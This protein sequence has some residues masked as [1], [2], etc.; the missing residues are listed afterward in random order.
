M[1]VSEICSDCAVSGCVSDLWFSVS[2]LCFFS[3]DQ[4]YHEIDSKNKGV[5]TFRQF[6]RWWKKTNMVITSLEERSLCLRVSIS[7]V[8]SVNP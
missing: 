7:C 3:G 8:P 1:F 6:I 5:L 4:V 2:D